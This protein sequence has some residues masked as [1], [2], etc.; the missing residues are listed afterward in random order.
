MTEEEA[1][2]LRKEVKHPTMPARIKF[3]HLVAIPSELDQR[4]NGNW[5]ETDQAR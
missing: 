1:R 3:E 4:E 2:Q 5:R